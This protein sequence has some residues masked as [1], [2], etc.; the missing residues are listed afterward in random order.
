MRKGRKGFGNALREGINSVTTKYFCVF[1]ADGSFDPKDLEKLEEKLDNGYHS[2]NSDICFLDLMNMFW[3]NYITH[4][5]GQRL[6]L[7][8]RHGQ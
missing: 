7:M 5:R 8:Q 6:Y 4:T 1:N 3:I 2:L